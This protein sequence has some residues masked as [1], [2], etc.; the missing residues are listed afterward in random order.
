MSA[1]RQYTAKDRLARSVK[2]INQLCRRIR[3]WPLREQQLRL[4]RV[5]QGHYA[6]YGISGNLERLSALHRAARRLWRKW[7]TRRTRQRTFAW[8]RFLRLLAR[9]PL[10][11]PRIVHRY[12]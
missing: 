5:L 1:V 12:T 6:Y 2:A 9:F 11:A 8:E 7:L 3:H 10:P 4:S